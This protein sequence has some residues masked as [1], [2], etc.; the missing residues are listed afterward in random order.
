MSIGTELKGIGG[1][2]SSHVNIHLRGGG[3][4]LSIEA[5]TG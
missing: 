1:D 3:G 5:I 2:V 4:W